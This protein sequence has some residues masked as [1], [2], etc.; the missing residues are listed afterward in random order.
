[1]NEQ[2]ERICKLS[3]RNYEASSLSNDKIR[4]N[5]ARFRLKS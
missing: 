5:G 4:I 3:M 2:W 1:M